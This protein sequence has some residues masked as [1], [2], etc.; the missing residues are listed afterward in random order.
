MGKVM[1]WL[2]GPAPTAQNIEHRAIDPISPQITIPPSRLDTVGDTELIST[3]NVFRA[4][5]ILSLG[6][7]QL[8]MD[9][10]RGNQILPRPSIV[11]NP[12]IQHNQRFRPWVKDNVSSLA[13]TGNAF[14]KITYNARKE[15]INI[16]VLNPHECEPTEN[17]KLSYGKSVKPLEPDEFRHLRLLTVPGRARGLG[18]IQAARLELG[19]AVK[20]TRYGAEFF[21]S[22]DTPSGI[23]KSDQ[24]LTP[25]QASQYKAQWQTRQAHE[26]AVLGNGLDYKPI[27]LSPEDAQFLQTRQFDTT[28]TARLFGI[29]ARLFLAVVEGGS[30]T[31][32]NVAQDDLTFVR[33]TLSDYLGEIEDNLSSVLPGIQEAR[34]NLDGLLRPDTKTRYEAHKVGIDAGFLLKSEA[35]EIEGLPPLDG[36]NEVNN[37]NQ[38][39]PDS[40]VSVPSE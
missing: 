5:H 31:Y 8:T 27:L 24:Y 38:R 17:G 22:G 2:L 15:P 33:W 36:I 1:D 29:P 14:W 40:D 28:A 3:I 19:G 39:T 25:D 7:A 10:W 6:A 11:R 12:D 18:P 4:A 34:F 23:L 35:R 30:N 37:D 26:V 21:V 20:V 32:A 16:E 9:V 13:L